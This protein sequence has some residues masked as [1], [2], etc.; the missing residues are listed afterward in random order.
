MVTGREHRMTEIFGRLAPAADIEVARTDSRY[1]RRHPAGA[2]EA[3]SPAADFRI[4]AAT[5]GS[6]DLACQNVLLVLLGASAPCS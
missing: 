4:G 6:G 5:P 3:Y 1:P 2:S